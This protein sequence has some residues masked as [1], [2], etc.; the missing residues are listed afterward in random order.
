MLVVFESARAS[1][2]APYD[3]SATT[4]PFFAELSR[5]GAL[6]ETAY[7][8]VPHTTKSLVSIHCGIYP[9]LDPEPYEAEAKVI[10]V[11]CLA[12]L[13]GDVGYA[14]AFFQ[15]AD[16]NFERRRELVE[17]FGF[18]LFV[19]KKSLA[20][21]GFDATNYL[22][23]EDRALLRPVMAWVDEQRAL[24]PLGLDSVFAPPLCVACRICGTAPFGQSAA[25]RLRE[26]TRLYRSVRPRS[27]RRIPAQRPA[28]PD[29]SL[30]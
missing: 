10:P 14:T 11:R 23:L 17:Q 16:A 24:C 13:L 27:V 30:S 9:R 26:H 12:A 1:S 18:D 8:V 3:P 2:F 15:P 4:T 29:P 22:G 19:G 7:A 5:A 25:E 6:V 21:N 28:R 20:S